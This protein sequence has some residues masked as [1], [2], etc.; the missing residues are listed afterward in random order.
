MKPDIQGI[1][2][3]ILAE[4]NLAAA[5]RRPDVSELM[6]SEG[7]AHIDVGGQLREVEGAQVEEDT[8]KAGIELIAG[9]L[10]D[11][12]NE[13]TKTN[14]DARLPDGS[15]L[16]VVYP[17]AVPL[18]VSLSIRKFV[19]HF[20]LSELVECGMLTREV[21]VLLEK[22]ALQ[23][24]NIAFS[25][26]TSSGKTSLANAIVREIPWN[27]R[28]ITVERPIEML[29]EQPY[30]VRMEVVPAL[31]G[32]EEVTAAMC[33]QRAMRQRPDYLIVGEVRG[34]EAFDAIDAFSTGHPGL[35]TVHS[36]SCKR[37][38][39]RLANLASPRYGGD[40]TLARQEVATALDLVVQLGR[41]EAGYRCVTEVFSV[42][43][44]D[45]KERRFDGDY[46]YEAP[47]GL[48]A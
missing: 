5:Y 28:I 18:G 9:Y 22:S 26:Q 44:Y 16:S 35:T 45:P 39:Q 25:G 13:H 23:Q 36:S 38:L 30:R 7:L 42:E 6:I 31:P 8:L 12:I 40:L 24:R 21:A 15:R 19:R 10:R 34:P 11:E 37:A 27:R 3:S 32:R 4:M 1:F 47:V 14:L 2:L 29:V 20:T 48:A 43:D 46:L 33:I 41:N 17:P